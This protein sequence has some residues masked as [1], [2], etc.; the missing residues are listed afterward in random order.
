MEFNILNKQANK[1]LFER[2]LSIR[3]VTDSLG[4][5]LNPEYKKYRNDPSTLSDID[6]ATDRIIKAIDNE[7][8]IMIFWDYDVDGIISS[9]IL[10]TFFRKYLKYH[11]I[12]IQLPHRQKDWYGI[13]SYHIDAIKELWCSVIITVDNWITANEEAMHAKEIWIDM[14]V[15]DHH[16]V[17]DNIPDAYAVINPQTS[18]KYLFKEICWAA[19]A[20]KL[21][22]HLAD[23][24]WLDT[25]KKNQFFDEV[26]PHI[27]IATVADCMPLIKENRLI[28]KKSLEK[29]NK[30]RD[31]LSSSLKWFL[32]YLEI[33]KVDTYHIGF[34][35]A[36]RLNAT[37]RMWSA[38]DWL[39]SLLCADQ[40]KQKKLLEKIDHINTERKE[41]Q[42]EMIQ[43]ANELTNTESHLISAADESF[44]AGIVWIVAW[45]LTEKY[46]KPSVILEVNKEKWIATWSLRWPEY[47]N[48]VDMLQDAKDLLLRF[49]WH[50]QAW[51]L[52]VSLDNLD[53]MIRKFET[54]CKTV[55][56]DTIPT[57]I[58]KV[59]TELTSQ[60][61]VPS[62]ID[63]LEQFGPYWIWNEKPLFI[64]HEVGV[65]KIDLI[66]KKE[67][68]HLKVHFQKDD[69]S[70]HGMRRGKWWE[71][72]STYLNTS[73]SIIWSI[74]R[75]DWNWGWYIDILEIIE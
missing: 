7:E 28:V 3:N 9:Y 17:L 33:Q 15:T 73:C 23:K 22:L 26:L 21:A 53:E 55:I 56:W 57:K 67:R 27:W 31:T 54:Y 69:I 51:W 11:N 38:H 59:D 46:Y 70:F 4:D 45:R 1:S 39:D 66:W 34:M 68:K 52:T 29:M 37:G 60:E 16:H 24:I 43:R 19:V 18:P 62:L 20:W 25:Q 71:E 36:P 35:I 40:G 64:I 61:L 32:D 72:Y 42:E 48:V 6:I 2:L 13:K 65:N 63:E 58:I 12:S 50:E 5:F 8:K 74:K 10:Y 41:I 44:H 14:I 75:D 49:W 30:D 47:F